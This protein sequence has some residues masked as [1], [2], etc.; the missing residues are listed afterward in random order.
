[1]SALICRTFLFSQNQKQLD[2]DWNPEPRAENN[3]L[4]L[5]T[6]TGSKCS[7][8]LQNGTDFGESDFKRE[9]RINWRGL[10]GDLGEM[11]VSQEGLLLKHE[12][13]QD[14]C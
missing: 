7:L 4:F 5:I 8:V 10:E 1:M 14:S 9:L 6:E 2:L 11:A 3:L 12:A 13:P